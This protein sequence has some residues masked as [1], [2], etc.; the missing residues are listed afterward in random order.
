MQVT[1]NVPQPRYRLKLNCKIMYFMNPVSTDVFCIRSYFVPHSLENGSFSEILDSLEE[2]WDSEAPRIGETGAQGWSSWTSHSPDVQSSSMENA[3][4]PAPPSSNLQF[5]DDA[6]GYQK[7]A[8]AEV[9]MD[10]SGWLPQRDE[11]DDPYS[12]VL[13]SDI[14]PLLFKPLHGSSELSMLLIFLHI[15]GLEIPGLS[16]S[17]ASDGNKGDDSTWSYNPFM[18]KPD[19]LGSLFAIERSESISLT[20]THQPKSIVPADEIIAGKERLM[21]HGWGPVK[22][23]ALGTRSLLEGY[24]PQGEGRMWEQADLECVNIEFIRCVILNTTPPPSLNDFELQTSFPVCERPDQVRGMGRVLDCV[25]SGG[26]HKRVGAVAF[27][28]VRL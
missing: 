3:M 26:E 19:L 6:D 4:V 5:S 22:N 7:W 8:A 24:G 25:R 12:T 11:T 14:R 21:G 27:G 16:E 17:L 23:W 15:L 10:A 18:T 28:F 2:F 20:G 1:L 13:F 9:R